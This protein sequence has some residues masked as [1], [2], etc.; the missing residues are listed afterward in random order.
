MQKLLMEH[1][2]AGR[3]FVAIFSVKKC[4]PVMRK[5]EEDALLIFNVTQ[6]NIARCI[7]VVR[8]KKKIKQSLHQPLM[9]ESKLSEDN[10]L[11]TLSVPQQ[12]IDQYF[13]TDQT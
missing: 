13:Q 8:I 10:A 12:Q 5:P 7:E 2:V 11:L 9:Q 1:A 3:E 6:Q 4:V